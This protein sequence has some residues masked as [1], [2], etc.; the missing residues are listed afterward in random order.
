MGAGALI[1]A[2]GTRTAFAAAP[3][4]DGANISAEA[5]A[6]YQRALVFDANASPP[7]SDKLPFPQ[8]RL[9]I[10]RQSGVTGVKTSLG[11]TD[12]SFEDTLAEI[13]FSQRIIE[14]Y[15]DL[16]MQVREAGDF[17]KAKET[18]RLGILFSFESSDMFDGKVERIELFRNLGVRV[19]QLSYNKISPFAAGV[20]ADPPTGLTEAGHKAVSA[21]N[22]TGVAIDL[23]HANPT[24]TSDVLA[25]SKKPALVTHA[26]CAAIYK[27]PRN[28]TDAQLRVVAAKGGVVGIYDLPYLAA[29]PKQPDLNVYMAHMTHALKICGEDHVGIGSDSSL[30]SFDTSPEAMAG[31]WKEVERRKQTGVGA[32]GED[33]P[34]YVI[35]LNTPRRCEVI[36]DAL[37]KRH[38]PARVAEK[39][40][41]ANF[42]GAL[43]N[44]WA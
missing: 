32:P 24:T 16:F 35:G 21:M 9:D 43:G 10:V 18:K 30:A 17:T 22:E 44:I 42:I 11:G 38:Y 36:A 39:V 12:E 25:A 1:V 40:L 13:A 28:K 15:P 7:V 20:L 33:R 27:H 34:P 41:G 23:S 29:S 4:A 31:F 37:L 26:G 3:A 2:A 19:M 8:E 6:L 14:A 5:H